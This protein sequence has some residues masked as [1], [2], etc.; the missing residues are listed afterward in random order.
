MSIQTEEY[1]DW[2]KMPEDYDF[3]HKQEDLDKQTPKI[4][5]RTDAVWEKFKL[6]DFFRSYYKIF[7]FDKESEEYMFQVPRDPLI[8]NYI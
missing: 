8:N 3:S 7:Y 6:L 2:A 5:F 4:K 1:P